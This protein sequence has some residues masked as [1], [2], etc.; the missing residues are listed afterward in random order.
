MLL[1]K[2]S[3]GRLNWE[4]PGGAAERDETPTETAVREVVEETGLRVRAER[5]TGVY[6]ERQAHGREA[7]HFVFSCR[8]VDML[9]V[10]R[11]SCDEITACG[12]WAPEALPRPLSDFTVRR[13]RDALAEPRPVLPEAIMPRQWLP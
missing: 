9:V 1:V 12:Y 6:Y 7:L 5:L 2:H 8:L 13:I 3:Y 11:P 4:L 10:P